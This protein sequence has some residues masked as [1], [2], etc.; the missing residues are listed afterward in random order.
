MFFA[1]TLH[2]F[3]TYQRLQKTVCDFSYFVSILSYLQKLKRPGFYALVFHIFIN[4]SRSKQNKKKSR[5]RFCGHYYVGN[6]RKI[7][8]KNTEVCGS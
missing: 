3:L 2:M 5:T 8:T 1:G 7:S 6:G 4:N